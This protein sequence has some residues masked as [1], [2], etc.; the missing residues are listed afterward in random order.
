MRA[1]ALASL[2]QSPLNGPPASMKF[3]LARTAYAL[4]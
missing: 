1:I 2:S 4:N 3:R